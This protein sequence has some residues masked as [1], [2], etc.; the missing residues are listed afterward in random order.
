VFSFNIDWENDDYDLSGVFLLSYYLPCA[1]LPGLSV[2][3]RLRSLCWLSM[4]MD[5][6]LPLEIPYS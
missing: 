1:L 6:P 5:L 2:V 4:I 3:A